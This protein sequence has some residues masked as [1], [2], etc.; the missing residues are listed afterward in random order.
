M[1]ELKDGGAHATLKM[2][3]LE[4]FFRDPR[5]S[6]SRGHDKLPPGCLEFYPLSKDNPKAFKDK[7]Y[8]E[9]VDPIIRS[10]RPNQAVVFA[11]P[12]GGTLLQGQ[13]EHGEMFGFA[14]GLSTAPP[15]QAELLRG[16][17]LREKNAMFRH[18][19]SGPLPWA[20]LVP[21]GLEID[22]R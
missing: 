18:L 1:L 10:L 19:P 16:A 3:M 7:F 15:R 6:N 21:R 11:L 12:G 22:K 13:D 17:Q 9:H 5:G 20:I 2:S 4:V 8:A 14:S